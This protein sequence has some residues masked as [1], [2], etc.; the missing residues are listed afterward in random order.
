MF[1]FF[2][3]WVSENQLELQQLGELKN[4]KTIYAPFDTSFLLDHVAA[5]HIKLSDSAVAINLAYSI[6]LLGR[7]TVAFISIVTALFL[8]AISFSKA[9]AAHYCKMDINITFTTW[10]FFNAINVIAVVWITSSTCD[11]V[12]SNILCVKF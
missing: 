7:I 4:L 6:Q 8:I 3:A 1:I 10:A 2:L 9:G 12:S 5:I 11:E